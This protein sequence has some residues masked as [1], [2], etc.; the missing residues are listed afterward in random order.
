MREDN[1]QIPAYDN[2]YGMIRGIDGEV[3]EESQQICHVSKTIERQTKSRVVKV[4][5]M[6]PIRWAE[7]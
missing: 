4:R 3:Y 2:L 7:Q 6:T 1:K 5:Q